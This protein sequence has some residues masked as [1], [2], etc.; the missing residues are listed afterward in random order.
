M[1]SIKWLGDT[2]KS[3]KSFPDDARRE[4]GYNLD[5]LQ[6]GLEPADWKPMRSVGQGVNEIR[7]HEGNEYRILYVAKFQEAIYVLHSFIKKTQQTSQKD[8][9]LGKQRYSEMLA[10]RREK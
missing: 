3:V 5:K 7:I 9:D 10:I 1:K 6:R 2:H 4:A 8:I